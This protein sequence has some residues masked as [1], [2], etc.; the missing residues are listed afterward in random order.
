MSNDCVRGLGS[1]FCRCVGSS[2]VAGEASET[3][4]LTD[5]G[6]DG[7]GIAAEAEDEEALAAEVGGA[8]DADADAPGPPGLVSVGQ[9][10]SRRLRLHPLQ[11]GFSSLHFFLR[12]RQ[13]K[14]PVLLLMIGMGRIVRRA[15]RGTRHTR[16]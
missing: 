10:Q 13:V 12:R 8:P 11:T 3:E 9:W 15:W 4:G 5:C 2:S 16:G 14:Q 1:G 6:P 7:A